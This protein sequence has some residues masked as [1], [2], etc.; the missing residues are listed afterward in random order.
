MHSPRVVKNLLGSYTNQFIYETIEKCRLC[1]IMLMHKNL[2]LGD[3]Q[4]ANILHVNISRRSLNLLNNF[5]IVNEIKKG[6]LT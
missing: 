3:P 1:S 6:T 5:R 2:I 4:A